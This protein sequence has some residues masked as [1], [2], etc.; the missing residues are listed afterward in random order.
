MQTRLQWTVVLSVALAL[1]AILAGCNTMRGFGR[2]VERG[3]ERVQDA[4]TNT[5]NKM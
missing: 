3:G 4:V 5:Q 1:G 2:D